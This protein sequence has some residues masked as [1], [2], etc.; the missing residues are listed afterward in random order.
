MG[1]SENVIAIDGPAGSGKSTTARLVAE[2]LGFMFLDTGAMY[3]ALT[4]KALRAGL[5]VADASEIS[6]LTSTTNIE[7]LQESGRL[8]VLLDREDVTKEIRSTVV[9]GNVANV[10]AHPAVR[11]W[12]VHMQ[13][14][15]GSGGNV[16]AEGRDVGTVIFPRARLKIF[17][18]A[19]IEERAKRRHK[20]LADKHQ[21]EDFESLIAKI[22]E[23]DA[24][25][26]SRQVGPLKRA[27][28]ALELDT[29]N[30]TVEQQVD[31]IVNKWTHENNNR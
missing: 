1:N 8:K 19:S 17:L 3:R 15:L 7:L 31:F 13:R 9:S 29:T 18:V 14:R 10:A 5:N 21:S 22:K 27:D 6:S 23:R 24:L 20:E 26:S 25:D 11:E 16:V 2:R 12:L 4:L 30:L 28:D